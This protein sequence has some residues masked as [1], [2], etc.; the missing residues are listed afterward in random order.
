[1]TEPVV[2][3]DGNCAL[4]ARVARLIDRGDRTGRLRIAV[5]GVEPGRTMISA[6]R[7]DPDDPASWVFIDETGRSWDRSDAV[8]RIAQR[9]T[10]PW[11]MLAA[12]RVIPRPWR[13]TGYRWMATHRTRLFGTADLCGTAPAS[14]RARLLD[15]PCGGGHALTEQHRR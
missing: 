14:L 7:L 2:I 6:A 11:R 1:M 13:D 5:A 15:A 3:L 9:L 4:C 8:I 10:F 12:L